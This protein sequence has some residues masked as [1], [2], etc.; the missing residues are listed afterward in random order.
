MKLALLN[1]SSAPNE[2]M[3]K[4]ATALK[5][6][7]VD[8][9]NAWERASIDV[10][11]YPGQELAPLGWSPLVAMEQPDQPG[12]EG[13]HDVDELD[14]AYGRAFRACIP[15]GEVL[16]D[17]AGAGASLAGV[18]AHEAAEM[19]LDILANAYQDG[20]FRDVATGKS[21]AQ[22]AVELADPVQE[23]AYQV[24]ADGE[25]VDVSNFI[26]PNWFD[27]RATHGPFDK[28]GV[29]TAPL[30]LAPGG[31]VIVRDAKPERQ[32]FA[33]LLGRA[34]PAGA[35]KI[36]APRPPAAWRDKM[37]LHHGGR[38]KRRLG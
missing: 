31:Y 17:K 38:T 12:A 5:L 18:L 30:T 24:Q 22:V 23:L 6:Y 33:R 36:A 10:A 16:H 20:P 21:Y 34:A 35:H 15:G 14:R 19:A 7:L 2:Q 1:L 25:P 32:I 37:K 13:Y 26:L 4:I 28:M 8:V 3:A 11:F 27:R 29:L 9:C